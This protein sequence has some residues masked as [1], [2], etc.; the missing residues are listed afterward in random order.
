MI[1]MKKM[2]EYTNKKMR[3][4]CVSILFFNCII[5]SVVLN[6]DTYIYDSYYYWNIADPV[7]NDGNFNIMLFPETFRGCLFPLSLLFAKKICKGVWGWRIMSSIMVST[8]FGIFV[9]KIMK[10]QISAVKD[11]FRIIAAELVFF[12][13]WGQF[14]QYPLSD[15]PAYFFFVAGIYFDIL[16]IEL[17]E[18]RDNAIFADI[19]KLIFGGGIRRLPICCV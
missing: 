9:P 18:K 14:L 7:F 6:I 5:L 8:L 2:M 3:L 4:F 19:K 1:K 17:F 12:Y 10:H 15:L 13:I 11:V 16:L